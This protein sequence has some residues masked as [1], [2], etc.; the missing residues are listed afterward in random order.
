MRLTGLIIIL[1]IFS[2]CE[3][4]FFPD[5]PVNSPVNNYNIFWEDFN[6]YYGQFDI[7]RVNWDSVNT[8]YRPQVNSKSTD[9]AL[10][11]VFNNIIQ[12]LK[13]GHVNVYSPLGVAGYNNLFPFNY[14]GGQLINPAK[15]IT[16]SPLQ[17]LVMSSGTI[18]SQNIGYINISTF[19]SDNFGNADPR[20]NL[21]DS[22]IS[23]LKDKDGI[24][25]DVRGNGGGNSVNAITVA[26]RFASKNHLYF[27]ERFKNGPGKND[28]SSWIDFYFGPQGNIQ[29]L[30]PVVVLTSRNTFSSAELFVCA[31]SVLPSVTLVGD[32]TGGGIGDPVTCELPIGWSL[33]LSTAVGAMANGQIIDGKGIAPKYAVVNTGQDTVS[34]NSSD[35]MLEKGIE[36]ILNSR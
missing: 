5:Q 1:I 33:R 6:L 10:F 2:G 25:I 28:Y 19:L 30:K 4:I 15:Y 26:S 12:L 31:M 13:D 32:T 35:P 16:F 22:I 8:I 14:F 9:T 18:N 3:K 36:V 7:R 11:N 24:I 29:F 27:K 21:I 23:Q 34:Y 17:N 20:Y